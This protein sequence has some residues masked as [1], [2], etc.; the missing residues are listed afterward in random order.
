MLQRYSDILIPLD[1]KSRHFRDMEV[2]HAQNFEE[3][4]A[5][6]SFEGGDEEY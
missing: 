3:R 6:L 4:P 5:A 1:F 2:V